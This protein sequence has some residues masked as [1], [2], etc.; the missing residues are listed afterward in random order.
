MGLGGCVASNAGTLAAALVLT[1]LWF[2]IANKAGRNPLMLF[3]SLICAPLVLTNV[4]T[5]MDYLWSLAFLLAALDAALEKR[6]IASGILTGIASGFR[7]SNLSFALPLFILVALGTGKH[8]SLR[9]TGAAVAAAAASFFPVLLTYG[10]PLHWFALT[11]AEM[12]DVYPAI[13]VRVLDFGYRIL[14]AAGPLASITIAGVVT[15]GRGRLREAVQQKDPII[16]SCIAALAVA[17]VQFFALP[18]ERAYLLPAFPFALLL[19]D[20]VSTPRASLAVLLCIVSLNVVNPD[21]IRHQRG[22]Y[23][24]EP[25][26][27]EGRLQESWRERTAMSELQDRLRR[28]GGTPLDAR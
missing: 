7:P 22:G 13:G 28:D 3:F 16:I 1:A 25:N 19:A 15:M 17:A 14:Y 4:A 5:T 9:Y 21:I 23:A 8:A 18:L 24:L 12:S 10:G 11:T 26:I 6:E 27:H 2:R 20:R